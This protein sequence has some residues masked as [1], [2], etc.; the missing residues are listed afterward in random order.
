MPDAARVY[1]CS[2][3]GKCFSAR[4][5]LGNHVIKNKTMCLSAVADITREE[6]IRDFELAYPVHQARPPPKKKEA[7]GVTEDA[8]YSAHLRNANRAYSMDAN[9]QRF[10]IAKMHLLEVKLDR[11]LAGGATP[12]V[13]AEAP[14]AVSAEQCVLR[15]R[16]CHGMLTDFMRSHS[17]WTWWALA[18]AL[19]GL[20]TI[21]DDRPS[22]LVVLFL[23]V[24]STM[25]SEAEVLMGAVPRC[26]PP[27]FPKSLERSLAQ[28]LQELRQPYRKIRFFAGEPVAWN[29]AQ[30]GLC[31]LQQ[32]LLGVA[33]G[34]ELEVNYKQAMCGLDMLV[35]ETVGAAQAWKDFAN[36]LLKHRAADALRF[37]E[38]WPGADCSTFAR[39]WV[40]DFVSTGY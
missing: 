4:Y 26:L 10:A 31:F 1:S 15:A 40:T 18:D 16:L 28:L 3:C 11:L 39:A 35:N 14:P 21:S 37:A 30:L 23:R 32:Q 6:M 34:I 22:V 8:I 29:T 9:A 2:R 20:K 24:V 13:A 12:S 27:G 17:D 7:A 38:S 19:K 36:A 25:L 5:L 33:S